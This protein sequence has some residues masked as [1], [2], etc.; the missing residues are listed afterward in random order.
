[1]SFS[2]YYSVKTFSFLQ[3]SKQ[4]YCFIH[5]KKKKKVFSVTVYSL[6]MTCTFTFFF[7]GGFCHLCQQMPLFHSDRLW[8]EGKKSRRCVCMQSA[9]ER[10]CL[11]KLV[12][13]R[14]LHQAHWL[15]WLI[16]QLRINS[17]Q[18]SLDMWS[19]HLTNWVFSIDDLFGKRQTSKTNKKRLFPCMNL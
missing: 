14:F 5:S 4:M 6:I 16:P 2:L 7:F 19:M 15:I 17:Q 18:H 8:P 3:H 10:P 1:M 11:G 12:T 9:A 13:W